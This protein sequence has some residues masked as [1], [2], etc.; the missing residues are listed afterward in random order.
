[1]MTTDKKLWEEY[2][3]INENIGNEYDTWAFGA[4]PDELL[5]L[6]LKGEKT[7]T[8]SL[9]KSYEREN[10]PT[11]K[12]GDYSVIL[13]SKNEAICIIQN[14][15]VQVIPFSEA[16]EE[17]AFKEGEGDKSLEY[18]RRVHIEFFEGCLKDRAE[19]FSEDMLIVYEEFKLV[20]RKKD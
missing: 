3:S 20:Y 4:S 2:K 13:N 10:E 5:D 14:I 9:Y 19:N 18:W 16:T 17:H 15:D 1:M 8:S 7:G 6:V 11:P 12:K